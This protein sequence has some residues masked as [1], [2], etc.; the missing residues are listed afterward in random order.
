MSRLSAGTG[1]PRTLPL[2]T[3]RVFQKEGVVRHRPAG[4]WKEGVVV[5][6]G[7]GS[8]GRLM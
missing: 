2:N 4:T 3:V 7:V 5:G 8:W 1:G 6:A